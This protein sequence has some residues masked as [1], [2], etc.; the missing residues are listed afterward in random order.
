MIKKYQ[1]AKKVVEQIKN[2]EWT[3]VY[4]HYFGRYYA[5]QKGEMIIS[6]HDCN[7]WKPYE[8]DIFGVFKPWVSCAMQSKVKAKVKEE[9][10]RRDIKIKSAIDNEIFGMRK[11]K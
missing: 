10:D 2:D 3:L 5:I 6:I 11:L 7:L 9:K 1:T 8:S 4:G